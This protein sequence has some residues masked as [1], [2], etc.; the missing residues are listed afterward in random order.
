MTLNSTNPPPSSAAGVHV[1]G[2]S[3]PLAVKVLA[4]LFVGLLC[5]QGW[6][7]I[8]RQPWRELGWQAGLFVLAVFVVIASG[9]WGILTSRTSIDD[10]CIRQSWLWPK[11]VALADITQVKLLQVPQLSWLVVPRLVVR[12]GAMHLTTFHAADPQVLAALRLLAYGGKV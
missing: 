10:R 3:F 12:S 7:L 1:E 11:E 2:P 5:A 9:Y 6:Q 8:D 4:T